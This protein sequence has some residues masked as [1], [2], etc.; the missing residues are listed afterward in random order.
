MLHPAEKLE[1]VPAVPIYLSPSIL[2]A[3]ENLFLFVDLLT[4]PT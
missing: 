1:N 4:A 3:D 2:A